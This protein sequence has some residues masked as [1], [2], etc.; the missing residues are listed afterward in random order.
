[1]TDQPVVTDGRRVLATDLDGT[2]I[3]LDGNQQNRSD[4][5]T[6][7]EH[8]MHH[9]VRLTYVTGR[10]FDSV[11]RAIEQ[12][13][14]P[15]PDWVICDVG[16]S[17][18][19]RQ[20][21]GVFELVEAYEG[22]QDR[23]IA[24]MPIR[25][26]RER[27]RSIDGL[28][29]QEEEKQ[30]RFK[31][32]FYADAAQVDNF[33]GLIQKQ[34]DQTNAPYSIIHSVDPFKGDGL[35]DVL[36]SSVSK[37]HALAWWVQRTAFRPDAI[38]FAGDSGNDLAVLTSGYRSIV[39]GNADREL[40]TRVYCAHREAGWKNR[41]Y[42]AR[43]LATSGVLE[44][45]RWF[46][47]AGSDDPSSP[48]Q[49]LGATPIGHSEAHFRV[50]A[51]RRRTVAVEIQAGGAKTRHPLTR[52]ENGYFCGNVLQAAPGTLYQYVLDDI[53]SRPDPASR[54]QPNG[55]H[56]ASQIVHPD[57]FPW[58]DQTWRGVAKR[59]LIIYEMHVG[60]FTQEG[61][62][63]SV[64]ERLPELV[65]L[66]VTAVEIM[67]V[68]QSPGRWNWGYDGVGLF[69]VRNTY[70]D[71]DDFKALID[72]CHLHGIAVILDV[73][74]NHLGPEG[75][76][77]ADFGPYFSRKHRTPWGEAFN[78][79]GRHS[80]H[81]RQYIID[82]AIYWLD[83]YHLD[84]LRLDAVHFMLDDGKPTILDE[85]REAVSRYAATTDRLVHLIAEAN[86]YDR[87]LLVAEKGR[88]AYDATWCDCLMHSIY[89]IA[90]PDLQL[91]H[92]QYHGAADLVEVL[93]HGYVYHFARRRPVRVSAKH[94]R[95]STQSQSAQGQNGQ[96]HTAFFVTALQTHDGVGN[97]PHGKRLHHLTSKAFQKAA[98]AITLLFPS[99]PLI[100]MG[101]EAATDSP[102]PFFADF[103]DPQLRKAVDAGRA[104]EYSQH[105]W[106]GALSPSQAEAFY[107]AKCHDASNGDAE[108]VAWYRDLIALRKAGVAEGW[109]CWACLSSACDPEL[110]VFSLQFA[111]VDGRDMTVQAR[112][113]SVD[114]QSVE[115]IS[116]PAIGDLVLSSEPI[117]K[118]GNDH[119]LLQPNHAVI[120]TG[121]TG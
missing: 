59:E 90:L 103:E 53:E 47:S 110:D 74:Y 42:L 66:G 96:P 80:Q 120:W 15:Q 88:T 71:P 69:A 40:A 73:V 5:R 116:M 39:V 48:A 36:P 109:L 76:Y 32:S 87:E 91:S 114:R 61:T 41:L 99:I 14:L 72:A 28:R 100:F 7:A 12:F 50:W 49:R 63:R 26:L 102:F 33:V 104:R 2:L 95:Q 29:L 70:G 113:T 37:A 60:A 101:E 81:V 56:G 11:A 117:A 64:I 1:M 54:C 92:R 57:A 89:S 13:Q 108:M 65:E 78:F 17:I 118:T 21:T 22:H 45:C 35:I 85:I 106:Q 119:I 6:L 55:V 46:G 121:R 3:P 16:T 62:F 25:T 111:G 97:H 58:T 68:A 43:S 93:R 23:I 27:L 84:G 75:N 8:L 24:A 112:L 52:Q 18:Y 94:R 98:A 82:N 79:D 86:V 107:R 4:L 77:L 51:P 10:H 34:L 20:T 19:Q 9:D 115:T 38:V 30:G 44:G 83:E 31:L 67:P 105:A